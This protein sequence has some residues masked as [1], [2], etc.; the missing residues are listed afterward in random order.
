LTTKRINH[1]LN[2]TITELE[3]KYKKKKT[4]PTHIS[5]YTN[6]CPKT[7][8]NTTK[9]KENTFKM[10]KTQATLTQIICKPKAKQ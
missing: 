5:H 6:L 7:R 8:P 2:P 9:E 1:T 4:H 10:M 3:A